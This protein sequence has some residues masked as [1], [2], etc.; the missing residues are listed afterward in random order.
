MSCYKELKI[1]A[2]EASFPFG[3]HI[4]QL[5]EL[6]REK[7]S[8]VKPVRCLTRKHVYPNNFE[9]KNVKGAIEIFF[10]HVTAALK[11]LKQHAG[12][13]TPKE[14]SYAGDTIDCIEI[15]FKWFS[16]HNIIGFNHLPL[17]DCTLQPFM[18]A[19]DSRLKWLEEDFFILH[20]NITN[21]IFPHI[22]HPRDL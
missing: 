5:Y 3:K 4:K 7:N 22:F 6:Q 2:L 17:A 8:L 20:P 13:F 1:S 18:S 21:F 19:E 12:H 9:K 10:P 15:I 16:L 11:F 14:F